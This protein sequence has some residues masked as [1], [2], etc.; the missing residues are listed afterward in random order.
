MFITLNMKHLCP[1]CASS[2]TNLESLVMQ[3]RE[4]ETV[5]EALT[6]TVISLNANIHLH[7]VENALKN[8]DLSWKL[9]EDENKQF[10]RGRL[11]NILNLSKAQ[12]LDVYDS[13]KG[14]MPD[15]LD[16]EIRECIA[17]MHHVF[18]TNFLVKCMLCT[19]FCVLFRNLISM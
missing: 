1:L 2:G 17:N 7:S 15:V 6:R 8:S 3:Q 14:R 16:R 11:Q 9:F 10:A 12:S 13:M 18:Y 5:T 19:V 4:N